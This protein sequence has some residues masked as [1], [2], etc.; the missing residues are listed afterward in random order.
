MS[1]LSS[2]VELWQISYFRDYHTNGRNAYRPPP[3]PSPLVGLQSYSLQAGVD[4]FLPA[5]ITLGKKLPNGNREWIL[6]GEENS[7]YV[8]EKK[9]PPNDWVPLMVVFNQTGTV[10]FVDP[11]QSN[12]AVKFYRAR[13]LD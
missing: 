10:T 7:H 6:M 4:Y 9:N 12:S 2:A 1:K 8:I 11:D 3:V 13:L 5:K